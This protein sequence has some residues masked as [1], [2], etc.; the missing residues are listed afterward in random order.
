VRNISGV[1]LVMTILLADGVSFWGENPNRWAK[2]N[3]ALL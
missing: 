2:S 3:A 1:L